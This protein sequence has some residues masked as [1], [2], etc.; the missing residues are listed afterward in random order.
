MSAPDTAEGNL[1]FLFAWPDATLEGD[2]HS[3]FEPRTFPGDAEVMEELVKRYLKLRRNAEGWK[4]RR[5]DHN[6]HRA[7]LQADLA[8]LLADAARLDRGEANSGTTICSSCGGVFLAQ[9]S[10][11]RYCSRACQQTAYR[12]RSEPIAA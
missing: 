10:S 6:N 1:R 8:A 4:P 11:A 7:I 2:W 9:R 12:E 3:V 5:H